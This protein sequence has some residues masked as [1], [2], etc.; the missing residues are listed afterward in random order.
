M[1]TG[2]SSG[3]A[4][5]FWCSYETA[6]DAQPIKGGCFD[7]DDAAVA[8]AAQ[9]YANSEKR[10]GDWP[11]TFL[12][13]PAGQI[14]KAKRFEVVLEYD[15][16]FCAY[17]MDDDDDDKKNVFLLCSFVVAGAVAILGGLVL[18]DCDASDK[19]NTHELR[20][21]AV[22]KCRMTPDEAE[23]VWP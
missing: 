14:D 8:A 7:A 12:V 15:P 17:A 21:A 5:V 11:P 20:K 22:E 1:T 18:K 9:Y 6:E 4:W 13:A 2:A 19:A 23:K 16:S 3:S 10:P